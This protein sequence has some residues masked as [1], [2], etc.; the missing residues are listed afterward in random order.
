MI[1]RYQGNAVLSVVPRDRV[2][3]AKKG[4]RWIVARRDGWRDHF[5]PT[6]T[7]FSTFT[8]AIRFAHSLVH[9]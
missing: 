6:S 5:S 4:N 7:Y 2:W 8:S 9:A 1:Y 3:V